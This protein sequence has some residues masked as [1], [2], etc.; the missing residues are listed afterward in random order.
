M[1]NR[2]FLTVVQLGRKLEFVLG[3]GLRV[4]V[5]PDILPDEIQDIAMF[6]GLNQKVRDAAAGFSRENNYSGAFRAMQQVADNL[7]DG[8]WNARGGPVT[9]DLVQAIAN[10]KGITIE[11]AFEIIDGLDDEQVKVVSSKPTV[12]A[13]MLQIKA[14]RAKKIAEASDDD[15]GI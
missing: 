6:H 8:L 2:K 1:A 15:L 11:D 5:E 3:N 13:A 14:E 10:L 12:K 9:A 4:E 7:R